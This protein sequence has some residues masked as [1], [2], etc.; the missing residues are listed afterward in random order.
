MPQRF[1]IP[2]TVGLSRLGTIA[3]YPLAGEKD[4]STAPTPKLVPLPHA[5]HERPVYDGTA[6]QL[7][8]LYPKHLQHE[9]QCE[10]DHG[11]FCQNNYGLKT[12][13]A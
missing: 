13:Q 3:T 5:Q 9:R 2:V 8:L 12:L 11:A 4:V 6:T 10:Q 7:L 1:R